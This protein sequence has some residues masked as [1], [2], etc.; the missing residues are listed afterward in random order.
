[1]LHISIPLFWVMILIIFFISAYLYPEP[2]IVFAL[3]VSVYKIFTLLFK[4]AVM[5]VIKTEIVDRQN[6]REQED[7][8]PE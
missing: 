2:A 8:E 6:K 3:I 7:T 4:M 1:M 5:R